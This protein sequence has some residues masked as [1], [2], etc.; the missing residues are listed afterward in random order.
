M[1]INYNTKNR[2]M[3]LEKIIND[4]NAFYLI[5]KVALIHKKN[6]DI[7]FKAVNVEKKQLKTRDA[8]IIGKSNVDYYGVYRGKFI[9]FECK[10]TEENK[11]PKHS[12]REHQ[13]EYLD[14]VMKFDG[15]A[16][17]ILFYKLTNEFILINHADFKKHFLKRKS[18]SNEEA[19]LIGKIVPL[20]FPGV[21][22]YL[23][24]L[25]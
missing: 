20:N 13:F 19:R 22:D 15:V 24:M 9:A 23:S 14:L 17:W 21:I 8:F 25:N 4:T 5:N 6:L 12:I 11:L 2:G 7:K 10:S 1:E 3:L 16:F 18:L